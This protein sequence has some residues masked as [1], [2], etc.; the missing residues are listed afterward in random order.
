M[1]DGLGQRTDEEIVVVGGGIG[2][3]SAAL[4]FARDGRRVRVLERADSFAEVGAG[5]QLAPNATRLLDRLGL[6]EAVQQ[7]GVTPARLVIADA[8]S[9]EGLASA[10]LGARF[11]R[12]FGA[13]YVVI[14]RH[15]LL[16]ILLTACQQ[17][18]VALETG[19]EVVRAV[20]QGPQAHIECADGSTYAAHAVI[21]ADGLRSALR[22][23]LHADGEP[24]ASGYVAYRGAL[25]IEQVERP[26]DLDTVIVWVGPGLHL[27]Q[28]PI[29]RGEMYNQVAVFRSPAYAA[30]AADW[31]TP[32]ELDE[33]FSAMCRP[34]R[35]AMP[36]LQ[37]NFR[38]PT[39]D[40][41][42]VDRWVD[43]RAAL[44][45]DAAHPMLQY[46]AQGA[47]QAIEDAVTVAQQFARHDTAS[48]GERGVERALAAYESIRAPRAARVQRAARAWGDIWHID[49]TGAMLRNELLRTIEDDDFSYADWLWGWRLPGD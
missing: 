32:E 44:L 24:V 33:A 7:A 37:R 16:Q 35:T 20:S 6:L 39:Y 3:L 34:V 31:G 28:Y 48:A 46:L 43:G 14:H 1:V 21:G 18:G 45:G 22:A 10:D 27:V 26:H 11:R 47:C 29:R 25:P 17:A 49:G 38:W 12:T 5:L 19:R 4:S 8:R 30:G 15:D 9:G 41:A 42:P 36:S 23:E 2:G 40:R 13:P